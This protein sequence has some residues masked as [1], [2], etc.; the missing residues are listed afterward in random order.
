MTPAEAD[1]LRRIETARITALVNADM[2]VAE[3]LHA[4]DYQLITPRGVALSK[5][6]YL[7]AVATRELHYLVSSRPPRWTSGATNR[8]RSSAI[9]CVSAF[10]G[11]RR[12]RSSAGTRTAIEATRA[13]GK[14]CGHRRRSCARTERGAVVR[15]Y[16][17]AHT[18]KSRPALPD[19]QSHTP[20]GVCARS[21]VRRSASR[22]CDPVSVLL[23]GLEA[24]ENLESVPSGW[25]VLLLRSNDVGPTTC[26]RMRST[27]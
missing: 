24:D 20:W 2:D 11:R 9:E 15:R 26:G 16:L 7:L 3:R 6:E 13:T 1:H 22:R 18:R 19:S 25:R 4:A 21:A 23:D 27:R 10:I 5:T 12:R 14:Q 17:V 8:S